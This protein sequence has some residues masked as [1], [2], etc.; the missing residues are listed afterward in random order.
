VTCWAR[1]ENQQPP[2]QRLAFYYSVVDDPELGFSI[3]GR[4]MILQKIFKKQ[5]APSD[6]SFQ[7]E[8]E[9]TFHLPAK[10]NA[11]EKVLHLISGKLVDTHDGIP[12]IRKQKAM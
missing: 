11:I 3:L 12:K 8:A 9:K 7:G 5:G 1:S 4:G 10:R 6:D 2:A